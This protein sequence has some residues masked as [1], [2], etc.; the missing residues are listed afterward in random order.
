MGFLGSVLALDTSKSK[1]DMNNI[2]KGGPALGSECSGRPMKVF[3]NNTMLRIWEIK[4]LLSVIPPGSSGQTLHS[5]SLQKIVTHL[6]S[7]HSVDTVKLQHTIHTVQIN[8][9]TAETP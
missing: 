8:T 5:I 7:F 9:T 2:D 1:F 3:S 6:S 4:W